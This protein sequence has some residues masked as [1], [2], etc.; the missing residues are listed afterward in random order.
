MESRVNRPKHVNDEPN[1]NKA[2]EVS[3]MFSPQ[4]KFVGGSNFS[5]TQIE[6]TQTH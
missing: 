5:L 6:K 1:H 3:S 4:G 2:S